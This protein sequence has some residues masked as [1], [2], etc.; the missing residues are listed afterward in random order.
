MAIEG[1]ANIDT[2]LI[3]A[4]VI[5]RDHVKSVH[6]QT[7]DHL[8]Q[9]DSLIQNAQRRF[10]TA[11][12]TPITSN[13]DFQ[14]TSVSSSAS[15]TSRRS[16]LT[17]DLITSTTTAS[18]PPPPQAGNFPNIS[19]LV[20][21]ADLKNVLSAAAAAT[22]VTNISRSTLEGNGEGNGSNNNTGSKYSWVF[23]VIAFGLPALSC[24]ENQ[25]SEGGRKLPV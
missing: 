1:K 24:R 16:W 23:V 22:P 21:L 4:E 20:T 15:P 14:S 8:F 18:Q 17:S 6:F 11:Y 25:H 10:S 9:R 2:L 12:A 13:L 7:K 3:A 19:S 5:E